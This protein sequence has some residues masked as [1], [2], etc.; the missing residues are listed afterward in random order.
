MGIFVSRSVLIKTNEMNDDELKQN[1]EHKVS[2]RITANLASFATMA[3]NQWWKSQP[4]KVNKMM[5]SP[6]ERPE[7]EKDTARYFLIA[8]T[9]R[10]REAAGEGN[11]T[12]KTDGGYVNRGEFEVNTGRG[13]ERHWR[14]SNVKVV[15][16]NIIELSKADCEDFNR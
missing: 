1:V 8:F 9:Y 6:F 2:L 11:K 3:Y 13:I 12:H 5:P 16:T 4:I 10:A 7:E 14:F 15:I